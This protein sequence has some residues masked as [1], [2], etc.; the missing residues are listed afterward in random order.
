MNCLMNRWSEGGHFNESLKTGAHE[1]KGLFNEFL[2]NNSE[3][4]KLNA[5]N[6]RKGLNAQLWPIKSINKHAQSYAKLKF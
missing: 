2:I 3:Y 5:V 1:C 6:S 4:V